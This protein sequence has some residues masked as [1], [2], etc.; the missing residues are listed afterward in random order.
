[1]FKTYLEIISQE[2]YKE[3]EEKNKKYLTSEKYKKR[4]EELLKRFF[5]DENNKIVNTIIVPYI[6]PHQQSLTQI[7]KDII[8]YLNEYG[9]KCTEESYWLGYCIN[10]KNKEISIIDV[11]KMISQYNIEKLEKQKQENLQYST[12]YDNRI[13]AKQNFKEN[14]LTYY[15]NFTKNRF[16]VIVFTWLP[17]AIASMSTDVGWT[18]CMDLYD[19]QY[20]NKVFPTIEAG[21]F[22]A[23]LVQKGDEEILDNPQAR[24]LIKVYTTKKGKIFWY[25]SIRIYGTASQDFYTKVKE[26]VLKKQEIYITDDELKDVYKCD[27]AQYLDASEPN[28][29]TLKNVFS[30]KYKKILENKLKNT[31]KF[32]IYNLYEAIQFNIDIHLIKKILENIKHKLREQDF[33]KILKLAHYYNNY[34]IINIIISNP[35]YNTLIN[36]NILLLYAIQ[37]NNIDIVKELLQQGVDPS[38]DDNYAIHIAIKNGYTEMVQLLLKDPRIDPNVHHNYIIRIAVAG[39]YI[40]IVKLLLKDQ[41]INPGDAN[42]YA[43]RIASEKGYTE[44]VKLLLQDP[45]VN[46][47]ND[48]NYAIRIAAE[49]GYIEIV[50]SLLKDSRVDPS[51]H[52]NDAIRCAVKNGHTEIVQLLL[53]DKRVNPSDV[54]N[55]AIRKATENGYTEIVQL[56]LQDPRVDPSTHNN[57]AIKIA[58]KNNY[59]KIVKLLL[60]N[61]RID[62]N[63]SF[64]DVIQIAAAHGYIKIVQLLLQDPRINFNNS[65]NDINYAIQKAIV[66]GHIEVVKLLLQD[67]R[68]DPSAL[69]NYALY[70]AIEKGHIEIVKLLLQDKRV[71]STININNMIQLAQKNG[72]TEII[73][74]LQ[75]YK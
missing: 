40:E 52:H 35:Q 71:R 51:D 54:N 38:I 34:D 17:R 6:S 1:M 23:W 46:P 33:E 55:Y 10:D 36:K 72:N 31:I 20:R 61:P 4:S 25:P 30:E 74:L 12:H 37:I 8:T 19:G 2:K 62:L 44:I 70:T 53:Q 65:N 22:I 42:N 24:I 3:F 11:L 69:K 26:F 59:I 43:I 28:K 45:R 16:K 63:K 32:T 57:Y 48:N 64:N 13:K 9:Y 75:Q 49:K 50:K 68:V 14:Y 39:G 5:T 60:Q 7:D 56:L 58:V 18:S 29:L 47:S 67:K 41:R 21:A 27:K 66:N 15:Q 73:Q